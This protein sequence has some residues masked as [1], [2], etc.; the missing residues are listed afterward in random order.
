MQP[1]NGPL[2]TGQELA[3]CV[4]GRRLGAGASSTVYAA[5]DP[6]DQAWRALKVFAAA[7]GT[8]AAQQAEMRSRFER[9]AAVAARLQHPDIVRLHRSGQHAGLAWLLLDLLTGTELT[10]Y[11]TPARLLPEAV[12][13]NLAERL[14]RALA[15]AHA[16][17]VVHRDLKPA[18]VMVDWATDQVT[19]TDFGIARQDD[20]SATRTGLVLGSPAYMA[21]ELLSGQPADARTDL[22]ALGVLL[23]QLLAGRLPFEAEGMGALLRQVATEPAPDLCALRPGLDPGLAAIAARLLA[24]APAD[25]PA[26]GTA[27]ADA[28]ASLRAG[29]PD[30]QR[31]TGPAPDLGADP[32]AKSR[33]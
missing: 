9:E 14:A 30:L 17:G 23:F 1:D 24:K 3:G 26:S 6:A 19:L 4:V 8:S 25:R 15:H 13:L 5:F 33:R 21:P 2:Q 27:A 29:S 18:N 16:Q 7:P 12:V 31:A 10:R 11:T 22:Y 28:L 20:A 32:G